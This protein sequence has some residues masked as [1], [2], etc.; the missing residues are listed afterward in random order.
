[1]LLGVDEVDQ[2]GVEVDNGER[3]GV[4]GWLLALD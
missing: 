1:M 2:R 4:Y 3:R